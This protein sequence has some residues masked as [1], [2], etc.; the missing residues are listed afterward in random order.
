MVAK[1]WCDD[2][3]L[4]SLVTPLHHGGERARRVDFAFLDGKRH[5]SK[6]RRAVEIARHQE[7]ARRQARKVIFVGTAGAEITG[8]E[9]G[10]PAHLLF[11]GLGARIGAG[12]KR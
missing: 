12:G 10:L 5:E 4:I 9:L 6:S 11:I 2:M 8:E 1:K 7:T 3:R